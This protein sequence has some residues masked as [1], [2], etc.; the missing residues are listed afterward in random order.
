MP[1]PEYVWIKVLDIPEEFID[2][3]NLAGRDRDGWI[4]FEIRQGCYGL[5]QAGIVANNLL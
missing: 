3:Y 5:N 2:E 4:Y 1:D